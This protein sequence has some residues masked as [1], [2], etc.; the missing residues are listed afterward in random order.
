MEEQHLSEVDNNRKKLLDDA[1]ENATK[2]NAAW[3]AAEN[4]EIE[5]I[6]NLIDE[7]HI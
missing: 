2:E 3:Q 6:R 1:I 5:R 7:L 4:A